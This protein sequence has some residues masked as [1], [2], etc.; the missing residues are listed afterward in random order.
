MVSFELENFGTFP[1]CLKIPEL[2][3]TFI[4]MMVARFATSDEVPVLFR[5]L[6]FVNT[7]GERDQGVDIDAV[8]FGTMVV[9]G[10]FLIVLLQFISRTKEQGS[11]MVN[12]NSTYASS[13]FF[14]KTDILGYFGCF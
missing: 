6:Q 10:F 2:V 13:F 12:T 8:F 3:V 14:K 9:F 7:E 11:V 4:T 5:N 1:E